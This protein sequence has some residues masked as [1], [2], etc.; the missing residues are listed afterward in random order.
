MESIQKFIN[1]V[2]VY[3]YENYKDF[4]LGLLVGLFVAWLYHKFIGNRNLK[5][6]YERLLTGKDETITAL[7][8]VIGGKL[9]GVQVDKKSAE[10]FARIRKFFRSG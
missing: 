3:G 9:A 10:F 1:Q 6:S 8:E 2:L 7:K 5:S 4:I